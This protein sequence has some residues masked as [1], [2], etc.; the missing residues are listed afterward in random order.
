MGKLNQ[1]VTEGISTPDVRVR[2]STADSNVI[3]ARRL[4]EVKDIRLSLEKEEK[5]LKAHFTEIIGKNGAL[6]AGGV[7]ISLVQ[8]C[9]KGLDKKRIEAD[10]GQDFILKYQKETIYTQVDVKKLGEVA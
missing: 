2:R 1:T 5:A 10:H 6:E 4:A 9:R 8:K 7:L 3:K